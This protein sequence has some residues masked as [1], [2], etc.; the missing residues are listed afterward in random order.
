MI[1]IIEKNIVPADVACLVDFGKDAFGRLEVVLNGRGG[2]NV[3]LAIGEAIKDGRLDREPGGYRCFKSQRLVLKP[4][5]HSYFFDIPQHRA[6][7]ASLP[8]CFPPASAGGEIAPFRYAEIDGY[9]GEFTARRYNVHAPFDD[10]AAEFESSDPVLNRIWEFCKY[11]IKATTPFDKYV[12]G[13]RERLP[14]EG[15]AYINQLGHFCCDVSFDIARNTIEH[16][17]E[18]PTWPTEWL[19]LTPL[20]VRDYYLY[21]GDRA[22]VERWYPRLKEKLLLDLAGSDGLIRGNTTV[23]DIVDWPLCERDGYEFGEVNLV[24]NCYHHQALLTMHELSGDDFYRDRAAVVRAA[25]RDKMLKNGRFVDNPDSEH[26]SLHGMMF[27]ALFGIAEPAE[28]PALAAAIRTKGMACSVYGAQFL[29]E[30]CYHIG[31]ADHAL[32]LMTASGLRSWLNMLEKGATITMEAWDDSL[33][34]NQDW[35]HAWGA[36]PANIIPRWLAGV[37]PLTPGFDS[38]LIDPRPGALEYFRLRHPT[39]HGAIELEYEPG[40]LQ[41]TVPENTTAVYQGRIYQPGRHHSDCI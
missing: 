40:N 37:R 8:K 20:L 32:T 23:R 34:P 28:L 39:R 25:I 22:G 38:F 35:N 11:S 14:Y 18:H 1:H 17:F 24:P 13:E 27:A 31:I 30:A 26:V 33:K 36:A 9:T 19:L 3:E 10:S 5:R 16:F 2:E 6:P 41:F 21:S 15:D 12:D 4:G 7:N 29:L